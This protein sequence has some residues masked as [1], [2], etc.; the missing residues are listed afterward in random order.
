MAHNAIEQLEVSGE[1]VLIIGCG[2]VGLLGCSMAKALGA[3][4]SGC[5]CI[6]ILYT[7]DLPSILW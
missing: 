5:S 2:P 4:R 1:D 7:Q 3:K 6:E